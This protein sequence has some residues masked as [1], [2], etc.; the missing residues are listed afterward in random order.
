MLAAKR[1]VHAAAE[2]PV[3]WENAT[4]SIVIR[5]QGRRAGPIRGHL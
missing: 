5:H 2:Q 1:Y 4:A 3:V